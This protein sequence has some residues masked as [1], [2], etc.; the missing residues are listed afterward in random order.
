MRFAFFAILVL[1]APTAALPVFV[2][3]LDA[4]GFPLPRE[5][6]RR[7]GSAK[8]L[9][10]Y[11]HSLAWSADGKTVYTNGFA[12]SAWDVTTG[13]C[14]WRA[15]GIGEVRSLAVSADGRAV[16]I[17]ESKYADKKHSCNL[18]KL[19][20][21]TGAKLS[22]RTLRDEFTMNAQVTARGRTVV[23]DH[24]LL[25]VF[26]PDVEK[27]IHVRKL[28]AEVQTM[29]ERELS[30]DGEWLLVAEPLQPN[31]VVQYRVVVV[32]VKTGKVAHE[33]KVPSA[34]HVGLRCGPSTFTVTLQGGYAPAD[35]DLR[36]LPTRVTRWDL[37]TGK[38][39][40]SAEVA[41]VG[42]RTSDA[43]VL[44]PNGDV[45]ALIVNKVPVLFDARTWK[46]LREFDAV[47]DAQAVA[48]SP[49]GKVLA[50]GGRAL[51]F[52]DVA[53]GKLLYDSAPFGDWG[54]DFR[55]ADGG[56]TVVQGSGV[57]GQIRYDVA[58]GKRTVVADDGPINLRLHECLVRDRDGLRQAKTISDPNRRRGDPRQGAIQLHAVGQ[59]GVVR[60][61]PAGVAKHHDR[62]NF[63]P[64]GR[65]LIGEQRFLA[66][67][68]DTTNG[69]KPVV[70]GWD[71]PDGNSAGFTGPIVV[72]CPR[73]RHLA[74]HQVNDENDEAGAWVVGVYELA[75]GKVV[76]RLT[77]T[78]LIYTGLHWSPDGTRLAFGGPKSAKDFGSSSGFVSVFDVTADR[79]V[80]D[81]QSVLD[82]PGTLAFATDGRTLFRTASDHIHLVEVATGGV[83]RTFA[84]GRAQRIAPHPDGRH[85]ATESAT[86]GVLLWDALS[87]PAPW[88]ADAGTLWAAL[89]GEATRAHAAI[90]TLVANPDKAIP[91]LKAKMAEVKPLSADRI[92]ALVA[93]LG[94]KDFATRDAAS[95][96]LLSHSDDAGP[97]LKSLV[98]DAGTSAEAKARAATL[99]AQV[100]PNTPDRLRV[101]R[102]VE[103]V[104]LIGTADAI[105]LLRA[106][107][108]GTTVRASEA[109]GALARLRK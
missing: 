91:L 61:L 98:A 41:P 95:K 7:L 49:D 24:E 85:F 39:L 74:V 44:S 62:L 76:K 106:W 81:A 32:E 45:A 68:W 17:A 72:P 35:P 21:A 19:D 75:T 31:E 71:A 18:L 58:T 2:P 9:C 102:A 57:F 16:W 40:G 13:K 96:E 94:D 77:G 88:P 70:V 60:E 33:L 38:E 104:E 8:F 101:L 25:E 36:W 50:V 93:R 12:P 27:P 3:R 52:V 53:T 59:P 29:R 14:L 55:F 15:T 46:R 87:S 28:T 30:P 66:T 6:V 67:V 10:G 78:G 63:S 26:D 86:D 103:A 92:A 84:S 4:D 1:S 89:R 48:F 108:V 42:L 37:K 69:A 47:R 22:E 105:L 80:L 90:R 109:S 97:A 65:Y 43:P 23:S 107:S 54:H 99:L 82:G 79:S 51:A 64:G 20:A 5:A 11:A 34:E 83:R 73:D 100:P 56:R